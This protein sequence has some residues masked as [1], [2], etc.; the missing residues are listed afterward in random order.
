MFI[1]D[2]QSDQIKR[3]HKVNFKMK[4]ERPQPLSLFQIQ[5][6]VTV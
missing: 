4:C 1:E 5:L 2:L 3:A 6:I